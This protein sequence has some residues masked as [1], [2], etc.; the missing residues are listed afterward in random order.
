MCKLK[1]FADDNFIAS[2]M[3]HLFSDRVENIVGKGENAGKQF[4][5]VYLSLL[6]VARLRDAPRR[7]LVV[8]GDSVKIQDETT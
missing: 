2:Q 7:Q 6:P 1:A 8:T 4:V 5:S 3:I